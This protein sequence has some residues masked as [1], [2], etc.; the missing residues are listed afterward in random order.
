MT[1]TVSIW[2]TSYT[3]TADGRFLMHERISRIQDENDA[4]GLSDDRVSERAALLDYLSAFYEAEEAK[5]EQA[6]REAEQR[7]NAAY[8]RRVA[9]EAEAEL[10]SL[11]GEPALPATHRIEFERT[12]ASGGVRREVADYGTEQGFLRALVRMGRQPERFHLIN[13]D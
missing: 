6:E 10:H 3:E 7:S 4:Y 1:S 13:I 8:G 9:A 2:G 11:R 12:E 5:R